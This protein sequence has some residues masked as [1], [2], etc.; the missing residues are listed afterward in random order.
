MGATKL[1]MRSEGTSA[2]DAKFAN[3][4]SASF[5]STL[6]PPPSS[7]FGFHFEAELSTETK[8]DESCILS[9]AFSDRGNRRQSCVAYSPVVARHHRGD[10]LLNVPT[11]ALCEI[12]R[13]IT[14]MNIVLGTQG[15]ELPIAH[16]RRSGDC[17]Y[18]ESAESVSEALEAADG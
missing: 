1:W 13:T 6:P 17:S 8:T 12:E 4:N 11:S 9:S 7:Y 3:V 15:V 18:R 5:G 14:H 10:V 16:V 2:K